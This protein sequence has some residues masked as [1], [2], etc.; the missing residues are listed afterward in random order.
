[1]NQRIIYRLEIKEGDHRKL[2]ITIQRGKL[3]ETY[4][5]NEEVFDKIKNFIKRN[6]LAQFSVSGISV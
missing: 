3:A 1:M 5:I 6:L 4:P 2:F